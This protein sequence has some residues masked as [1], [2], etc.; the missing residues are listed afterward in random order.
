[1]PVQPLAGRV[2]AFT[3][4]LKDV[5]RGPG[6]DSPPKNKAGWG[7][8]HRAWRPG[9]ISRLE[10]SWLWGDSGLFPSIGG[11]GWG[12]AEGVSHPACP[13]IALLSPQP[14]LPHLPMVPAPRANCSLAAMTLVDVLEACL[15]QSSLS[16]CEAVSLIPPS[17]GGRNCGSGR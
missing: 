5:P 10:N 2:L 13:A 3:S 16:P 4:A 7:K 15:V 14:Q 17:S 6:A 11:V 1:M 9:L 12:A 8:S